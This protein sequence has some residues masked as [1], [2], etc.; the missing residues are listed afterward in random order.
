MA[1]A[2]L[3]PRAHPRLRT[4]SCSVPEVGAPA[5]STVIMEAWEDSV[6]SEKLGFDASKDWWQK[7]SRLQSPGGE[8]QTSKRNSAPSAVFLSRLPAGRCCPLWERGG[9][10]SVN[11]PRKYPHTH[12]EMCLSIDPRSHIP[13][14]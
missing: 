13:L 2:P 3:C 5:A 11:P 14:S 10:L 9:P 6:H 12:S 1:L 7:Q 4:E 8:R